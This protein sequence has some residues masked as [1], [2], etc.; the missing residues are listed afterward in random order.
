MKIYE[1]FGLNKDP[2]SMIPDPSL[3]YESKPHSSALMRVLF[4][5]ENNRGA[6]AITGDVGTGKS[7]LLRKILLSLYENEYYEPI[8]FI[9][10]HSEFEREWFLKKLLN[11]YGEEN[12]LSFSFLVKRIMERYENNREKPVL[13]VDEA[14]KIKNKDVLEDLR[15][16]LNLEVLDEKI[17]HLVLVGSKKLADNLKFHMPFYQRI[18]VWFELTA[19]SKEEVG[20][21]IKFRLK[22]CGGN[23]GI[24]TSEA[25]EKVAEYSDGIPRLINVIC[26][27][28]LLEAYI[29]KK[30]V[31]DEE[32]IERVV[33]MRGL[34]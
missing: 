13:L 24:F 29:D 17:F 15:N 6:V 10:A 18:A 16:L 2:F 8:L 19:F 23:P 25:I 11:F 3:F 5:I 33:S 30:E 32:I 28:A 22:K 4:A 12:N 14:D 20:D 9:C 26:D 1:Y 27:S 21:Y 31:V 7:I 34:K